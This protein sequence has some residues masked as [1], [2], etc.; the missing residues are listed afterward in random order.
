MEEHMYKRI[1]VATD[2]SESAAKALHQAIALGK[3]LGAQIKIVHVTPPWRTLDVSLAADA[4]VRNPI[5]DYEEL[6]ARS[7]RR[8]LGAAEETAKAAGIACDTIHVADTVPAEG[9]VTTARDNDCDLIVMGTHGRRGLRQL[10]LGS[11][12]TEVLARSVIPVLV[13]R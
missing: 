5:G 12:T 3:A 10:L 11:Q 4:G 7:A 13:V 6:A 2:G 8:I 9:I 1:L